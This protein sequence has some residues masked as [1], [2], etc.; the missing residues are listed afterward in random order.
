MSLQ[1]APLESWVAVWG[2]N[3]RLAAGKDFQSVPSICLK[4]GRVLHPPP[5][6]LFLI[7]TESKSV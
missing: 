3:L 2:P 1:G 7:H 6:H 5:K 4:D